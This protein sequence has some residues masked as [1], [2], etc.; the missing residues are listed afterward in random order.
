MADRRE[1]LSGDGQSESEREQRQT[2]GAD[3]T[4][5]Q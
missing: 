3:L 1:G 4:A 5:A 2:R